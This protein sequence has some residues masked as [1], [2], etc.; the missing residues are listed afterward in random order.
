MAAWLCAR[1][2]AGGSGL[3]CTSDFQPVADS[4]SLTPFSLTR[5]LPDG[6]FRASRFFDIQAGIVDNET[7]LTDVDS[8]EAVQ[9]IAWQQEERLG[10]WAEAGPGGRWLDDRYFLIPQTF[11]Q[12]PLLVQAGHA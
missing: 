5:P 9:A 3:P 12:G 4:Q 11:D 7:T 2:A 6:Q 10:D 8:G 1:R